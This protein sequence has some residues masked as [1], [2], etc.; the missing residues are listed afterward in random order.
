MINEI[1]LGPV[2]HFKESW[3]SGMQIKK[4]GQVFH[5]GST[6]R[7]T[8]NN[9]ATEPSFTYDAATGEYTVSEGWALVSVGVGQTFLENLLSGAI[10]PALADNLKSW[11]SRANLSVLSRFADAVRTTAGD[12]S[13]VSSAGAKLMSV[14][15]KTDFYASALRFTGRNLL[16]DAVA[17]GD[18][19]YFLVPALPFGTFG[20]AT[21]PN[22]LLFTN[23]AGENLTPTVRFKALSAGVPTSVA[24]GDA[25]AY[26][27]SNGYRFYNPT[28]VGYI[29]VSGITRASTCAK[30]A[31]SYGYD[32]YIAIDAASDAGGSIAL[33]TA[34]HALH[35]YDLM[36][37][38]GGVADR[39]DYSSDTQLRWVRNCDRVKPTW[40]NVD[41]GD[42]TY[43]H[44]ATISTMRSGGE[45]E[46]GN[47]NMAVNDQ[48]I[49]YTDENA[50]ATGDWVKFE[51]ATPD[52]GTVNVSPLASVDDMGLEVLQGISG[53]AIVL[54]A[55]AQGYPDS[56][57]AL[58][59]GVLDEITA[60][61]AQV[62]TNVENRVAA[63]EDQIRD[64]FGTLVVENLE[65][66]KSLNNFTTEGNT[67]ASGAG[68]PD[69]IP[70]RIGQEYFDTT[71]KVWYDATDFT[72]EGWKPRTNS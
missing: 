35:S 71:N 62:V 60:A 48:T 70:V 13:I 1:E 34:I 39:I 64:G 55:Y 66:R 38:A 49:S 2:P 12:D 43:T 32:D 68:A 27:D 10:V 61:V 45:V 67:N 69:F 44:F 11:A 7:A 56:V 15:P 50:S 22:G 31:W 18:G 26:T 19:W 16:R 59:A 6:Y 72:V 36:L 52:T 5:N 8:V 9:P 51:L 42:G 25:C 29:I 41:N 57:A 3:V 53:S 24:D 40:T 28:E 37:V 65:V 47:L 63:L 58:V 23:S 33:S 30:V 21:K 14:V 54:L 4:E 46:C 17:V 20:T